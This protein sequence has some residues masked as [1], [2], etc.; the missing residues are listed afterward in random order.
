M[1]SVLQAQ[2]LPPFSSSKSPSSLQSS[3]SN[4]P[5]PVPALQEP[6]PDAPNLDL[7]CE[8][9][10][11]TAPEKFNPAVAI[12]RC[13]RR[14][15]DRIVQTK[16]SNEKIVSSD[17]Q[18]AEPVDLGRK[19]SILEGFR[20]Y[21]LGQGKNEDPSLTLSAK[22]D[23]NPFR[24]LITMAT[25]KKSKCDV[26][27]ESPCDNEHPIDFK[28][29]ATPKAKHSG[30]DEQI[31][32]SNQPAIKPPSNLQK[33]YY[34]LGFLHRNKCRVSLTE[35]AET[36]SLV[37]KHQKSTLRIR[38]KS[39]TSKKHVAEALCQQGR[40]TT[41]ISNKNPTQTK[42]TPSEATYT[43]GYFSN[44]CSKPP[45]EEMSRYEK[46]CWVRLNSSQQKGEVQESRVTLDSFAE[47]EKTLFQELV[48]AVSFVPGLTPQ[49]TTT[50]NQTPTPHKDPLRN[51]TTFSDLSSYN[52]QIR[53]ESLIQSESILASTIPV[54]LLPSQ[55]TPI[56]ANDKHPPHFQ[57]ARDCFPNQSTVPATPMQNSVGAS[58][59]LIQTHSWEYFRTADRNLVRASRLLQPNDSVI[60]TFL[61]NRKDINEQYNDL[62]QT[63][64]ICYRD[65]IN[66]N[67]QP[68]QLT[69]VHMPIE[70]WIIIFTLAAN[71]PTQL[72]E[73]TRTSRYLRSIWNTGSMKTRVMIASKFCGLGIEDNVLLEDEASKIL[74]AAR[75]SVTGMEKSAITTF[76]LKYKR[77]VQFLS[78]PDA[79]DMVEVL[80]R[81]GALPSIKSTTANSRKVPKTRKKPSPL[82][83]IENFERMWTRAAYDARSYQVLDTLLQ[84]GYK[85]YYSIHKAAEFD[86]PELCLLLITNGYTVDEV[87][88][89][90]GKSTPLHCAARHGSIKVA[91]LLVRLDVRIDSF[92]HEGISPLHAAIRGSQ[93][94]M[95]HFLFKVGGPRLLNTC[96][97]T[98]NSV[99]PL[100]LA[101]TLRNIEIMRILYDLGA[102]IF[103]RDNDDS[104]LLH[105]A[106]RSGSLKVLQFFLENQFTELE[107]LT[108]PCNKYHASIAPIR[109]AASREMISEFT[110]TESA[111]F[112]SR[113][114]WSSHINFTRFH[115]N[116]TNVQ[117]TPLVEAVI[118]NSLDC[119]KYLLDFDHGYENNM[120]S[121]MQVACEFGAV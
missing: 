104:T 101:T 25:G 8:P 65:Q 96:G 114:R 68:K 20:S 109:S 57:S 93:V 112:E 31:M 54:K 77:L 60:T 45:K 39:L 61:S 78:Q 88:S 10:V 17:D 53:T 75:R 108:D 79:L 33:I 9:T 69:Y 103:I 116:G 34:F 48:M 41:S 81:T 85:S 42:D 55:P 24:T 71:S 117:I 92:D 1:A 66:C 35:D 29:T 30:G 62:V 18:D 12:S 70:L 59:N 40:Q 91:S 89:N 7:T 120:K 113:R 2:S 90:A 98:P 87:T 74:K 64:A 121:L 73:F 80:L 11:S 36:P 76:K 32:A 100:S 110:L 37:P 14:I 3:S 111:E 82:Q 107:G 46:K 52:G 19:K 58:C 15:A 26:N 5:L 13:I 86:D 23:K 4:V 72:A 56:S 21:K 27:E 83:P 95:I 16:L 84:A 99:T 28:A 102:D 67:H 44:W 43:K 51:A 106:A 97:P 49:L 38:L 119:F 50:S 47:S 63:T 94:E 22:P 118:N 6:M 115:I 105:V